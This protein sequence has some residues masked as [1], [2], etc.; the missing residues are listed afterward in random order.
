M[1]PIHV[2]PDTPTQAFLDVLKQQGF[3][4]EIDTS[5]A[6]RAVY[7]TDNS[8]YERPPQAIVCPKQVADL[9]VLTRLLAEERFRG[10]VGEDGFNEVQRFAAWLKN[11]PARDAILRHL[12]NDARD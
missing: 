6:Q 5:V 4:G 9:Q 10:V 7:A 3:A 8:I 1:I 2:M 12:N 11:Q